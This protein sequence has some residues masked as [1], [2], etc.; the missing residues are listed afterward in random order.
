MTVTSPD[1]LAS[2]WRASWQGAIALTLIWIVCRAL[3]RRLPADAH[4]WLWRLGYVKLLVG[5]LWGGAIFLPVL[6]PAPSLPPQ[7][8]NTSIAIPMSAPASSAANIANV[9]P[10]GSLDAPRSDPWRNWQTLLAAVYAV[11]IAICLIRLCI[12]ARRTH[13][14]LQLAIPIDAGPETDCAADLAH[15]IGL[16]RVPML[17]RSA[18][19]DSPVFLAGRI[20]LPAAADY[21]EADLRMILAHELAHARRRDLAWEWLGIAAQIAFFFHPLVVVA[22]REERLARE[23]AADSLALRATDADPA[24]YGRMLLA[25]ALEPSRSHPTLAGAVGVI[26]GG[27][28][29]RRRLLALRDGAKFRCGRRTAIVLA[30]LM[31][32]AL[33]PWQVTHGQAVAP[34]A[35]PPSAVS[36]NFPKM[37]AGDKSII[38][39]VRDENGKP[40][41][42]LE[43]DL[44]WAWSQ[45]APMSNVTSFMEVGLNL[46]GHV[47]TDA[48]G[49]FRFSGLPAG[50]FDCEVISP[51]EQYVRTRIALEVNKSDSVKTLAIAVSTGALVTGRVVNSMTHQ[52]MAGVSVGAGNVPPGKKPMNL[53][54]TSLTQT[55]AQGRYKFRV[56]PGYVAISIGRIT[57]PSLNP[58]IQRM[59]QVVQVQS[60]TTFEMADVPVY[61]NPAIICVGPDEKP[62]AGAR[63]Y[64]TRLE[65]AKKGYG[66]FGLTDST[67]MFVLDGKNGSFS[68]RLGA[69][70]VAGKFHW[71]PGSPLTIT[72]GSKTTSHPSNLANVVLPEAPSAEI[73]GQ[74]VSPQG[75][76]IP[77]ALVRID[78]SDPKT[79][80][81]IGQRTVKADSSGVFHATLYLNQQNYVC[82]RAD[83]FNQVNISNRL[84][85]LKT[86]TATD[87]GAIRLVHANGYIAG[88]LVDTS[89][90]PMKGVLAAARGG[91]TLV[92]AALTDT[93]GRFHIPNIVSGETLRLKFCLRGVVPDSGDPG[94]MS[95]QKMEISGVRA[96]TKEMEIVWR[97]EK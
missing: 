47:S 39:V 15:R 86:G 2:L 83:K 19:V 58:R 77:N 54:M 10:P 97:P 46:V 41:S 85:A 32:L 87:L 65:G 64:V 80:Y 96:S 9:V 76:P 44:N 70:T 28:P 16:R 71:S 11:G 90:K 35:V 62:I 21:A 48:Q 51:A 75:K 95:N 4:C 53:A 45:D 1:L 6:T 33:T 5:L 20:L 52:P 63:Y 82:I 61:F 67:G 69:R 42:G 34:T 88:R 3:A 18:I 73:T 81:G 49:R 25:L 56:M 36:S 17:A 57:D 78:E 31:G 59:L 37:P 89:G 38:G 8:Q 43:V 74:I 40:V 68:I 7:P 72:V 91:K 93:Q 14:A 84:P 13:R 26:E 12:A 23:A 94:E 29:L 50:K 92:S 24:S 79:Q 55:D 22:R 60:G 66:G 30:L 27:S